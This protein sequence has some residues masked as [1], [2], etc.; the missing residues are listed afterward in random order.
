MFHLKL[1]LQP[2]YESLL[3]EQVT[4]KLSGSRRYQLAHYFCSNVGPDVP[5]L[6]E[7]EFEARSLNDGIRTIGNTDPVGIDSQIAQRGLEL[8][9]T[10]VIVISRVKVDVHVLL[11]V[12]DYNCFSGRDATLFD[13][14]YFIC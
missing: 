1:D 5:D 7:L 13:N 2:V 12:A 3:S 4:S 6:S 14:I 10:P 11:S 9:S 8:A